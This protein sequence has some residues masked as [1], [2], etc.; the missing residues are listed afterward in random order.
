MMIEPSMNNEI[1]NSR[2]NFSK[3][4]L[5]N[6]SGIVAS[7]FK[8]LPPNEDKKKYQPGLKKKK[9]LINL[10]DELSDLN[11]TKNQKQ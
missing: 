6:D 11:H 7:L 2:S 4:R 1:L 5:A 8:A 10:T 3:N 9:D